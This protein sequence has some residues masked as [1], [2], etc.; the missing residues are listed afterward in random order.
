MVYTE[1]RGCV[2]VWRIEN[3]TNDGRVMQI[4]WI[5]AHEPK[6]GGK[7]LCDLKNWVTHYS[8][9]SYKHG[10][11]GFFRSVITDLKCYVHYGFNY[12]RHF[13][14]ALTVTEIGRHGLERHEGHKLERSGRCVQM[15]YRLWSGIDRLSRH[16]RN[17]R[18]LWL[19]HLNA[20]RYIAIGVLL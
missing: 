18:A 8:C 19:G 11:R 17:M 1:T 3:T 4:Y 16:Q 13:K 12:T 9:R 10:G 2:P 15:K 7:C 5:K 20:I 6:P 14:M